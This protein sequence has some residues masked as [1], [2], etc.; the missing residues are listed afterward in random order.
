LNG[1]SVLDGE[2]TCARR[3]RRQAGLRGHLRA[4]PTDASGRPARPASC[5][6]I[7]S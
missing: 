3:A 1:A 6:T 5:I 4:G 2:A 7:T